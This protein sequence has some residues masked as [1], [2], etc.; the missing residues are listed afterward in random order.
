[1][2]YGLGVLRTSISFRLARLGFGR[3]TIFEGLQR[4]RPEANARHGA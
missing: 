3:G 4:G 1:V 2:I